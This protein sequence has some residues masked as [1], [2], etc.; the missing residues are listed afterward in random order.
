VL[1]A[2]VVGPGVD[3][4]VLDVVVETVGGVGGDGGVDFGGGITGAVVDVVVGDG[5]KLPDKQ[6]I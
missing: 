1:L 2:A 4:V 5:L 3:E 6:I